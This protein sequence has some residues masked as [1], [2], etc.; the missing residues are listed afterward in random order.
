MPSQPNIHKRQIKASRRSLLAQL[1]V[2]ACRHTRRLLMWSRCGVAEELLLLSAGRQSVWWLA[3]SLNRCF[4][5]VPGLY[6]L[7]DDDPSPSCLSVHPSSFGAAEQSIG[8]RLLWKLLFVAIF[9][10]FLNGKIYHL[11]YD[12]WQKVI[13]TFAELAE[14]VIFKCCYLQVNPLVRSHFR[15]FHFLMNFA[16]ICQL[17]FQ[18]NRWKNKNK[19]MNQKRLTW[20]SWEHIFPNFLWNFYLSFLIELSRRS[21]ALSFII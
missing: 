11:Q 4:R 12:N 21:R 17:L 16:L 5:V 13:C 6:S 3:V 9:R 18:N 2:P 8:E 15:K 1:V 19:K 14:S 10:Y 7:H 20:R